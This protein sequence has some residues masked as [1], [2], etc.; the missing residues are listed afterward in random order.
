MLAF[1]AELSYSKTLDGVI[2][3]MGYARTED[4]TQ[5]PDNSATQLCL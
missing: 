1:K 5:A 4:I 2:G 3:L